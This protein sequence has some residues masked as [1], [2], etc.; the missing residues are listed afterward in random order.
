MRHFFLP[1]LRPCLLRLAALL[2]GLLSAAVPHA[3]AQEFFYEG[4]CYKVLDEEA[5]TAEV[6]INED[7]VGDVVIPAQVVGEG[8]TYKVTKIGDYAFWNSRNKTISSVVIP[9]SVDSIGEGAFGQCYVLTSVDIPDSVVSIGLGAFY[10]CQNLTSVKIGKAVKTIGERAFRG[11]VGLT[12]VTIP[13]SVVSVGHNAFLRCNSIKRV[14]YED[15]EEPIYAGATGSYDFDYHAS[16][17]PFDDS[18]VLEYVYLGRDFGENYSLERGLTFN[19][20]TVVIGPKVTYIGFRVFS[21]VTTPITIPNSV[22]KIGKEAFLNCQSESITL[23]DSLEIIGQAAF[24]RCNNITSVILPNTV[25]EIGYEA[26]HDCANLSYLSIPASLEKMYAKTFSTCPKLKTVEIQEG[27]AK[28]ETYGKNFMQWEVFSQSPIE[29][30]IIG[31]QMVYPEDSSPFKEWGSL[32]EVWLTGGMKSVPKGLLLGCK[33][34]ER[35][36]IS[37]GAE[38][39][40]AEAFAKCSALKQVTLGRS[41]KKIKSDAFSNCDAVTDIYAA[42][43]V[44]PTAYPFTL[45]DIDKS[46]CTLHHP[47]GAPYS[48]ADQWCDFF[49]NDNEFGITLDRTNVKAKEGTVFALRANISNPTVRSAE[50]EVTWR[51]GNPYIATVDDRGNVTVHKEEQV[52]IAAFLPTG[53]MASC[54]VNG[55]KGEW[56]DGAIDDI[57]AEETAGGEIVVYNLQGNLVLRTEDA[58]GLDRLTPG[59]YIV[60]GKKVAIR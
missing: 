30:L 59:I 47:A 2:C 27:T 13:S 57:A 31:R 38:S 34:L 52:T 15:G 36:Y 22:V 1:C 45:D 50:G 11:C 6:S 48:T 49:R 12:E 35:V 23:P 17:G 60:N 3:S 42:P 20:P 19:A 43:T 51:T 37:D 28:L 8:G 44:P 24:Q 53:E 9:N 39:I 21:S 18:E 33:G 54:L 40:E 55:P 25:K 46:I 7:V 5:K 10:D 29:K 14:I 41:V 16:G 58:A 32:K 26:F 4:L 56:I